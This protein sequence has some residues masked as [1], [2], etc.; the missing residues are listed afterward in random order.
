M[1]PCCRAGL[2]TGTV[3]GGGV[4]LALLRLT[5]LASSPEVAAAGVC[6]TCSAGVDSAGREASSWWEL[7]PGWE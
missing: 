5:R 6:A 2:A 7:E 1:Q 3:M 4:L